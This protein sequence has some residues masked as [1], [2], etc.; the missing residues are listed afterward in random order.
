MSDT[1]ISEFIDGGSFQSTD[2]IAI[3]RGA[4]NLKIPASALAPFLGVTGTIDS[5][6]DGVPVLNQP[7]AT[8]NEIRTIEGGIG[9]LTELTPEDGVRAKTNFTNGAGGVG[10][11]K[12]FTTP[13]TL[14][15]SLAAG[16]GINISTSG[17]TIQIASTSTV[18]STKTSIIA[19]ESDFPTP[20]AGI[21]NL[22]DMIDYL[23]T[24][25]ITTA[26]KIAFPVGGGALIRGPDNTIIS[27][28]YTG[29]GD[30]F[31]GQD[32]NIKFKDLTVSCP[33]GTLL[34]STSPTS[35]GSVQM[36]EVVVSSCDK[37]GSIDAIPRFLAENVSW[38]DI[39][40]TGLIFT[41]ANGNMLQ[42]G[43]VLVLNGGDFIDIGTSTFNNI[44]IINKL[45]AASAAGTNFIKGT[46]ASGN[47]NAGGL[48]TILNNRFAGGITPLSG[49]STNDSLWEFRGNDGIADTRTDG[50]LSIQGNAVNT[51][52]ATQSVGVLAAGV[53]KV[54]LESQT[55]A[56]TAG[57][58]T[59]DIAKS[60]RLPITAS[61]TLA[62][63]SG[64]AQLMGAAIAINGVVDLDSL[65]TGSASPGSP[66]SVTAPWQHD[67]APDDFVEIF[68]SNE[69]GT[70]DVLVSSA[71]F[72]VN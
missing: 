54:K 38:S 57:R 65:R 58:I 72:R 25:D 47:I 44:S 6:G 11:I 36:A 16:T 62:P 61:V 70:T 59:S 42:S 21:I 15:R 32:S 13:Q 5:K 27:L 46:T 12:D 20:I 34:K 66:A 24:Q 39:K 2:S 29:T 9:I 45:T 17:D 28:T 8:T 52:I 63:A 14:F 53:W 55:T 41:G 33:N 30:M 64:G 37:G 35:K 56:T 1:K 68:V 3:V 43:G 26:N 22:V 40:T 51:V 4:T 71:T 49:I 50:L 67:F 18:A 10:I 23:L 48:G 31:T 60:A 7:D 69:S 19:Q